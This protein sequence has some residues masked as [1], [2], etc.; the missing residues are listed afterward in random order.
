M[1]L[2]D[3]AW[4]TNKEEKLD[5]AM[6]ALR[7]ISDEEKLRDAA[8][9]ALLPEIRLE[10]VSRIENEKLLR[11]IVLGEETN[12]DA[13]KAA[14]Q[15]I[16]D[17]AILR[18][19][20]VMRSAYP[21][22]GEAIA[23]LENIALLKEIA[24]SETGHE[25]SKAVYKIKDQQ[26]LKEIAE[27]GE[28]GEAR[29]TAIRCMTDPDML[30]D[31]MEGTSERFIITEAFHRFDELLRGMPR[32]DKIGEWHER[33]L[34]IVLKENQKDAVVNLDYFQ[35]TDELERIFQQAVREDL[36]AEAFSRLISMRVF[37]P[38]NLKEACKEAFIH[39]LAVGDSKDNP[40]NTVLKN[41]ETRILNTHDP[42]LLLECIGDSMAGCVFA[43]M[44]LKELF[45]ERFQDEA[46][47]DY[48]RD[49]GVAAYIGNIQ[50]FIF[51]QDKYDMDDC[52]RLLSDAVPR[53]E[54]E[55]KWY[56]RFL[57]RVQ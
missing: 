53:E 32:N 18:E 27:K 13:R 30:L 19:I 35:Q 41:L 8:M 24:M 56:R 10:A 52:L 39:S 31:L 45:G 26:I 15:K 20:A 42:A 36:R 57:R 25:Q 34:N 40:W 29:K 11:E 14:I 7:A 16:S 33:Y 55:N 49:Q 47:I 17:E 5:E 6:A 1:S 23:K 46:G 37:S 50:S 28:K 22:D 48:I 44:C 54:A 21:A 3:P 38:H 9:S 2:F 43:S 4:K 51:L 12:F